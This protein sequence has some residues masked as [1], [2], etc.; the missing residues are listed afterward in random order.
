MLDAGTAAELALT[1]LLETH[2]YPTGDP[3]QEAL[4]DRYKTLGGLKDLA[5]Q[6]I[7]D[8]VPDQLKPEL[9]T[10]RN[11]AA[12]RAKE[13]VPKETAVKAIAKAAEGS[14]RLCIQLNANRVAR[15]P[16]LTAARFE[17][18]PLSGRR[19]PIGF[20]SARADM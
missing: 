15:K 1:A 12:H 4:F 2:L 6:L 8:K 13:D 14:W 17:Q 3:I 16:A 9:I 11:A 19:V 5:L 18:L 20:G 10:P 7:P